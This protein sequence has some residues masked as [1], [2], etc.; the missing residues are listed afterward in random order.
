[1]RSIKA[2]F[3]REKKTPNVSDYIAFHR[4][5][6]G[7]KFTEKAIREN[8]LELVDKQDYNPAIKESLISQLV[9][10]SYKKSSWGRGLLGVNCPVE[11]FIFK[12]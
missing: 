1:M 6:R 7:Q 12:S 2:R 11:P 3:N 5:I 9:G 8:F 10:V 4:A